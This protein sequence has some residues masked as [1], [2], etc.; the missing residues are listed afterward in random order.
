MSMPLKVLWSEGLTLGPQQ[1]QQQDRY[2]EAR[3]QH[4]TA[5]LNPHLWGVQRAQWNHDALAN[6]VL[7]ADEMALI[8]QDG[9]IVEAPLADPLP[10][11]VDLGALPAGTQHFTFYAA[12]PGLRA[13]GGN[14]HEGGARYAAVSKETPD[15]YS[16]ALNIEVVSLAKQVRL[17]SDSEPRG[18]HSAFPV[19][20]IR[21][22][23]SGG[24]EVDPDFVPASLSVGSAPG[25]QQMLD[26][27][28]VK[29][30]AKVAA[31]YER[32]RQPSKDV[33][34]VHSGD[35]SSFWMLNTVITA[36]ASLTHVSRYRRHHP[37][38]LFDRLITF[39]GSLMAFSTKYTLAELPAYRHDDPAPAFAR[40]DAIVRDL[41]DTVISSRYLMIPLLQDEHR[42]TTYRARL[43]AARIDRHV[44]LCLGVNAD[45]PALKLVALVPSRFKIAGPNEI[46]G[47]IS[48]ALSGIDLVHMAQVP[49]EVPMRPNT[50]YFSIEPKG[51][52]FEKMLKAQALTVYV[53]EG[54][55]NLRLELF[56][57]TA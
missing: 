57:I 30:Q 44:R 6:N 5:V 40:L 42:T 34:E 3:L 13:H 36:A 38:L 50:F 45:M 32:H 15:L 39:T 48:S 7:A 10:A 26:K 54:F 21:R 12:L 20:R 1:M 23:A 43:D 31:L 2:H 51:A 41:V 46:D 55:D 16:D 29:L 17:L 25:L 9:E 28:L 56:A 49:V 18:E 47:I 4:M 53:P 24:F 14:L 27:L 52:L 35:L 8:F 33:V 22:L 11:P 19:V 37:E